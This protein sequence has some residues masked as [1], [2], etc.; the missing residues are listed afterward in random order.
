ME[1]QASRLTG[2]QKENGSFYERVWGRE[3]R[4][5]GQG[6]A[7][8][9]KSDEG[10]ISSQWPFPPESIIS[11]EEN[12]SV[13]GSKHSWTW[14]HKL[15]EERESTRDWKR[16]GLIRRTEKDA[17]ERTGFYLEGMSCCLQMSPCSGG[18]CMKTGGPSAQADPVC[19]QQALHLLATT[20]LEILMMDS[21]AENSAGT[22]QHSHFSR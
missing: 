4:Y 9:W 8:S 18:W 7:G 5:I 19:S 2:E 12:L 22:G 6:A 17:L 11:Q 13:L 20:L 16:R 3:M 15:L 14:S 1:T 10:F 21:C